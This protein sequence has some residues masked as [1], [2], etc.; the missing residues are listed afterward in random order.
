MDLTQNADLPQN[1]QAQVVAKSVD[2]EVWPWHEFFKGANGIAHAEDA[3]TAD[4]LQK[5][6]AEQAKLDST[7]DAAHDAAQPKPHTF[8]LRPVS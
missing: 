6:Q 2:S 7:R 8:E 5:L 4:E 1:K 3:P